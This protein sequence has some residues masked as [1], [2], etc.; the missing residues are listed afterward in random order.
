MVANAFDG[1]VDLIRMTLTSS[2]NDQLAEI[3]EGLRSYRATE[4][5][6]ASVICNGGETTY[7]SRLYNSVFTT[8]R[9]LDD[10][11]DPRDVDKD[12]R[13]RRLTP[14]SLFLRRAQ[15]QMIAPKTFFIVSQGKRSQRLRVMLQEAIA[16][17]GLEL[18]MRVEDEA[19]SLCS[20]EQMLSMPHQ[21]VGGWI[22]DDVLLRNIS[23]HVGIISPSCMKMDYA[24]IF[25]A[26]MNSEGK[27][28]L[29][30]NEYKLEVSMSNR[31]GFDLTLASERRK[32]SKK[33]SR[34]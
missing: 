31:A 2:A 21:G 32:A 11:N 16:M 8:T 34:R 12:A 30:A 18:V 22:C 7:L 6:C 4:R 20:W 1:L 23:G 26:M 3:Q 24:N 25:S 9:L 19:Q 5:T 28:Y 33:G 27:V 10:G 29:H 14:S 17:A 13:Q 15:E